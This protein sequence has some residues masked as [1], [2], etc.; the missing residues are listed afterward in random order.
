MTRRDEL[1]LHAAEVGLQNQEARAGTAKV[2]AS[3]FAAVGP[4]IGVGALAVE[5]GGQGWR[6]A[7]VVAMA[8]IAVAAAAVFFL[9]RRYALDP[10]R[11]AQEAEDADDDDLARHLM[12]VQLVIYEVNEPAL[13]QVLGALYVEALAVA[14]VVVAAVVLLT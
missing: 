9:D 1:L 13:R 11:R 3:L 14:V 4:T 12:E 2:A 5:D 7:V 6:V 10:V 8:A